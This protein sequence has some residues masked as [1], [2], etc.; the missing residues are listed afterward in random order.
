MPILR[1]CHCNYCSFYRL[2]A[3]TDASKTLLCA[4]IHERVWLY[5]F[6]VHVWRLFTCKFYQWHKERMSYC[7][8]DKVCDVFASATCPEGWRWSVDTPAIW[9]SCMA[10][11]LAGT[12]SLS[13]RWPS[14]RR[15]ASSSHWPPACSSE[16]PRRPTGTRRPPR[17]GSRSHPRRRRPTASSRTP[18]TAAAPT[19]RS[20]L[21]AGN[22]RHAARLENLGRRIPHRSLRTEPRLS[23][24]PQYNRQ[25]CRLNSFL[26]SELKLEDR[27]QSLL[28]QCTACLKQISY[29]ET[30]AQHFYA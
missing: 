3:E 27:R 10:D 8:V 16:Q 21:Y 29:T 13:G 25:F 15:V 22:I 12:E 18:T 23:N 24:L 6:I 17:P 28:C 1:S 30:A 7:Y 26:S 2:W 9:S 19:D 5:S 4:L 11:H 14:G 20:Q